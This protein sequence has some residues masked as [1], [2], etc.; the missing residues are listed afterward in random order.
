METTEMIWILVRQIA[1]M[2]LYAPTCF[3]L[4]FN[5][6]QQAKKTKTILVK[7]IKQPKQI[8]KCCLMLF[9]ALYVTIK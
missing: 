3:C 1:Q 8:C 5:F 2:F 6:R 9:P 7:I 4:F